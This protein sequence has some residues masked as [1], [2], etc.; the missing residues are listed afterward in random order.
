MQA[1][2]FLTHITDDKQIIVPTD[3]VDKLRG[4]LKVRVIILIE[5][6]EEAVWQATTAEAFLAGY[7]SEDAIYDTL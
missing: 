5:E 4:Q 2:E 3:F 6:V 7:D 1:I